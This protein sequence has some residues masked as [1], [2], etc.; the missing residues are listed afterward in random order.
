MPRK[1]F[2]VKVSFSFE[3]DATSE[4][5]AREMVVDQL[6]EWIEDLAPERIEAAAKAAV[7]IEP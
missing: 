5:A 1:I 2:W 4:E 6:G 7:I 3:M